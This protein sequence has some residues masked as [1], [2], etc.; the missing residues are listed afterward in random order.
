MAGC[1]IRTSLLGLLWLAS[2][3]LQAA[4]VTGLV[5]GTVEGK[6]LALDLYLPEAKAAP[7]VVYVHGG[8]W[9][10]GD[11]MAGAAFARRLVAE[12]FAVASVDFRQST[13]APFPANVQDIKSA[14]RYLRAKAA[15]H[16]YDATRIA[17]TGESSGAHLA[18]LAGV[19]AGVAELEGSAGGN[20]GQSSA[21]QAI[22]SYF[23][24]TDLTTILAQSTPFGV[25]VRE[26]ALKLL[27]GDLPEQR[28]DLARLA[29][30]VLH[31]DAGDPPLFLLHGD[32]D[33]QMPINQTLQM[34]GVYK[35]ASLPVTL[36][37]VHGAA[38]G[39][40]AFFTAEHQRQVVEFLQ[41]HLR[42]EAVTQPGLQ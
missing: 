19:T 4:E 38:H 8:A 16:G 18:L 22:V 29:S 24:A 6:S 9:R 3:V 11:R 39:G 33:P 40:D 25:G 21:V 31:V 37:V 13:E 26:P 5:Y 17:L 36:D 2:A 30:P 15:E 34:W 23:A 1:I 42:S 14:I 32:R 28:P 12:G 35:A 7:L 20:P 10:A 41:Q 27:L